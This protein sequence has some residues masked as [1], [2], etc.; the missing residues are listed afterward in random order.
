[1]LLD[2]FFLM[3]ITVF[4]CVRHALNS[5]GADDVII[6]FIGFVFALNHLSEGAYSV[7]R[8]SEW[9]VLPRVLHWPCLTDA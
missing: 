7:T 5:F 6:S 9:C 2:F 8:I 3:S 4:W 1:M